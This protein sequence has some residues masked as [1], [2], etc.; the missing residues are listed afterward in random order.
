MFLQ[1][2]TFVYTEVDIDVRSVHKK[3]DNNVPNKR[4][5]S[6][7][8]PWILGTGAANGAAKALKGRA[9]KIKD[10]EAAA[11]GKKKSK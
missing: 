8:K 1:S 3:E 11:L 5:V 6:P 10:A 9:Q 4:D 7:P 2:C